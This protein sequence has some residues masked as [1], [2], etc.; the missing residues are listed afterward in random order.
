MSGSLVSAMLAG[1][2]ASIASSAHRKICFLSDLQSVAPVQE[3][4]FSRCSSWVL[5]SCFQYISNA[6]QRSPEVS[7]MLINVLGC[8]SQF[9]SCNSGKLFTPSSRNQKHRARDTTICSKYQ[10]NL[11]F[12]KIM[13]HGWLSYSSFLTCRNRCF[14][15]PKSVLCDSLVEY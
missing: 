4:T 7:S 15:T 5:K 14:R 3:Y 1:W 2:S 10:T 12:F 11:L 6:S 9:Q 13:N 8:W